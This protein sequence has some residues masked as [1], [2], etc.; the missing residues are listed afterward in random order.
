VPIANPQ[1]DRFKRGQAVELVFTTDSSIASIAGWA[2]R[3]SLALYQGGPVL[4]SKTVGSGVTIDSATQTTVTLDA[5]DTNNIAPGLY[6]FDLQR[7]DTGSE[8]NVA[9]GTLYF[10]VDVG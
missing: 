3:F 7:T 4:V 9:W 6:Y 5:N 1:N 10:D 8:T 2:L